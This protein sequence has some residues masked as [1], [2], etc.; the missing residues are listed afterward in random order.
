MSTQL[1]Y[2]ADLATELDCR[3]Q[4]VHKVTKALRI[5]P[6]K[7]RASFSKGQRASAVT[8]EEAERIRVE[9]LRRRSRSTTKIETDT[10]GAGSDVGEFYAVVVDPVRPCRIKL[11]FSAD[12]GRR[13]NDY[14]IIAPEARV[15]FSYPC[16][17]TWEFTSIAVLTNLDGCTKIGAELYDVA[18]VDALVERAEMFFE[19]LPTPDA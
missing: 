12:L 15:L 6:K 2:L 7:L 19:L 4:H 13:L 8:T 3:R 18:D 16:R 14:R 9:I 10:S 1:V 17:R 5:E 11:G